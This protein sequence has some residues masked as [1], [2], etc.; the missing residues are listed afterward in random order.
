MSGIWY[1]LGLVVVVV[2]VYIACKNGRNSGQAEEVIRV[3]QENGMLR[4]QLGRFEQEK[5]IWRINLPN[6]KLKKP[7]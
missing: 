7:I 1:V 4:E 3:L 6:W 5:S 2:I